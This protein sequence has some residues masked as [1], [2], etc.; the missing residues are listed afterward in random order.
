ME[1]PL[2][3]V[4]S[5]D[6]RFVIGIHLD[7]DPGSPRWLLVKVRVI[8]GVT[9]Q[10]YAERSTQG[11]MPEV[12]ELLEQVA[13]ELALL[14]E[15]SSGAPF[16]WGGLALG[17]TVASGVLATAGA[18]LAT[19][20]VRRFL[21]LQN[22]PPDPVQDLQPFEAFSSR[23]IAQAEQGVAIGLLAGAVV[24]IPLAYLFWRKDNPT[25]TSSVGF[26]LSAHG[27][28]LVLGGQLP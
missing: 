28:S 17:T 13:Q 16:P 10:R 15:P 8:D 25:L 9:G 11:R 1:C 12:F 24:G 2:E 26:T 7:T 5:L 18:V 21:Q 3:E 22:T 27:G 20:S 4:A 14:V 19:D 6:A 23:R